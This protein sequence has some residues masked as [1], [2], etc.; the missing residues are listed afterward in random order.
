MNEQ[1][2]IIIAK[3]LSGEATAA[4]MRELEAWLAADA[5]HKAEYE[6]IMKL[7]QS[8]D[9]F[10]AQ[11]FDTAAAWQKMAGKTITTA[12]PERQ[13]TVKFPLWGK[14]LVAAA[15]ILLA[16]I[17]IIKPFSQTAMVEI[18]ATNDNIDLVLPDSSHIT[19][20]KG[21][22][23]TYPEV[24]AAHQRNVSL[25]GEAYFQVARD[26]SKP[27]V[28]DA[29]AAS[30]KVLGTSFDVVCDETTASVK[31]TSGKVQMTSAKNKQT[32]V[33]LTKGE[34]GD[35]K[36]DKL[37]EAPITDSNFLFWKNKELVYDNQPFGK[38]IEDLSVVYN[39]SISI[40]LSM[41][42]QVA[43]QQITISF[44]NQSLEEALDELCL[45]AHCQ[46]QQKGNQYVIM[47]K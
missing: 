4:E 5:R 15:A 46:W 34:Q 23:I 32:Y 38:I 16:G 27:F 45:V 21:S 18:A 20:R 37:T 44:N 26:E 2:D 47:A 8:E 41:V 25:D 43:E 19:L 17:F 33:I 36:A 3:K 7:W 40:D 42:P 12:T 24:F 30:V 31:V 13:K 10:S 22:K 35:L 1:I 28:I 39:A 9:L 11:N 29:G 6:Q 14:Y